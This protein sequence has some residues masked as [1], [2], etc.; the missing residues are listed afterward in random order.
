VLTL[1]AAVILISTWILCSSQVLED[2]VP[3]SLLC[4]L[5]VTEEEVFKCEVV[6][7]P[8]GSHSGLVTTL[9]RV[10]GTMSISGFS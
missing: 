4:F 8:V 3:W 7:V 1:S 5:E 10:R 2:G 9:K 6:R